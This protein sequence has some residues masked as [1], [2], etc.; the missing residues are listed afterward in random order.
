MIE[1]N[2]FNDG[3]II[4]MLVDVEKM[5]FEGKVDESEV[6]KIIENLFLEIIVG[7]IENVIFDVVLDYIVFKGV[8]ENGVI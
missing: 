4:V 5:I 8:S 7:V 3:I 1:V 6:G 2:N